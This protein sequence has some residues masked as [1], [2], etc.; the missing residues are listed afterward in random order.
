[1]R[2]TPPTTISATLSRSTARLYTPGFAP[3]NSLTAAA[4]YQTSIG[5]FKNPA[6]ESFLSYKSARLIPRGFDSN[7]IN[8][9]NYFAAS[10][11]YRLPVWYPEGGIPSVLYFKRIRLNL[12]A[13]YGQFDAFDYR[14]GRTETRRIHSFGGDLYVDFNVFR[15]PASATSTLRLS[16]YAPSK[17]GLWWSASLGLPF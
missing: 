2:S 8:S 1:M 12:G 14:K 15:Q 6:G 4:T 11:D 10:L 17:G 13:D 9:R 7:D 16:F 3:H 5:G